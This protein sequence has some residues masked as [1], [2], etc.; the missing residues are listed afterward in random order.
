VAY[1]F[2]AP[3][4][5]DTV[6]IVPSQDHDATGRASGFRAPSTFSVQFSD[7]NSTWTTDTT[8]SAVSGWRYPNTL[9]FTLLSPGPTVTVATTSDLNPSFVGQSVDF[10]ANISDT[11]VVVFKDGSTVLCGTV[12]VSGNAAGCT[13][14]ALATGTHQI[15][16]TYAGVTSNVLSQVVNTPPPPINVFFSAATSAPAGNDSN[17]CT[18][19][20]PCL[21]LAKAQSLSYPPGSTINFHGGDTLPG[22]WKL[23]AT[24]NV[25]TRGIPGNPIVVQSYGTGKA[26]WTGTAACAGH[27]T[28]LFSAQ[29]DGLTIQNLKVSAAGQQITWGIALE[30]PANTVIIQNNEVSGFNDAVG[31]PE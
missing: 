19:A 7:D 18:Q 17:P 27:N 4:A 13:T 8:F 6:A 26:I 29:L 31:P 15:T 30:G 1:D 21:T 16:A 22:C 9:A 12:P 2:G 28:A 11:G 14:T 25:P 24:I 23:G 5:V 20:A 10:F 3:V